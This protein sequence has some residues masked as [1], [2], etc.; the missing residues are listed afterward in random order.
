MN[1]EIYDAIIVGAGPAGLT[2]AIYLGR[3]GYKTLVCEK[4]TVGGKITS[5]PDVRNIPGF[6]EISGLDFGDRLYQQALQSGAEVVIDEIVS[7]NKLSENSYYSLYTAAKEEYKALS[8][9]FA[10]GTNNRLLGIPGE[11]ELMG[12][13]LHLCVTCDGPFYAGKSVAVIGGGNSAITEAL[14]LAQISRHVTVLQN[15]PQLTAEKALVDELLKKDNVTIRT[16]IWLCSFGIKN[17]QLAVHFLYNDAASL[18]PSA[19]LVDGAFIA[20][21]LEPQGKAFENVIGLLDGGYME[22]ASSSNPGVFSAGDCSYNNMKQVVTAC[23]DGAEAANA[24]M[25]F[26]RR[27][28]N[29]CKN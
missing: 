6:L 27:A 16:G 25:N 3:A 2:A 19:L 17:E 14:A 29:L 15:L 13:R 9:V 7:V 11:K 12:R 22:H 4:E 18:S 20:A 24:A 26:L 5:S 28:E 21:G 1:A 8:I 10:V 23:A